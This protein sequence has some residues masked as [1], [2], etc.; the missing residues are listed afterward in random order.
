LNEISIGEA[1]R[2]SGLKRDQIIYIERRGY[3]GAVLRRRDARLFTEAQVT[4][5]QRIAALRSMGLG[6]AEAAPMF[7]GLDGHSRAEREQLWSLAVDKAAQIE[8]DLAAWIY[9]LAMLRAGH[10]GSDE[11]AA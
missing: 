3:L 6:L 9:V 4:K 1:A 7:G 10:G 5:L 11:D 8:R 2:R